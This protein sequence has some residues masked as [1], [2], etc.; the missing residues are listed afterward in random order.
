[1]KAER[2]DRWKRTT[3]WVRSVKL[4]RC[5]PP[6]PVAFLRWQLRQQPRD[7]GERQRSIWRSIAS[8]HGCKERAGDGDGGGRRKLSRR[9]PVQ[10]DSN[11]HGVLP[12]FQLFASTFRPPFC[13]LYSFSCAAF[14]EVI[15]WRSAAAVGALQR[16]VEERISAMDASLSVCDGR[17]PHCV[18]KRVLAF[19]SRFHSTRRTRFVTQHLP[20]TSFILDLD[21]ISI[22]ARQGSN[23]YIVASA[24]HTTP[25][26]GRHPRLCALCRPKEGARR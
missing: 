21:L 16:R 13:D 9:K 17:L 14:V 1:M 4:R 8:L 26:P 11:C 22:A 5:V 15:F 10:L 12:T 23:P 20:T 3:S 25:K 18:L 24:R 6:A 2:I 19:P 7:I